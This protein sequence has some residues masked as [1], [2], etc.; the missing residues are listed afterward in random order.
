METQAKVVH[1][2]APVESQNSAVHPTIAV[3][4][5]TDAVHRPVAVKT[6]AKFVHSF[7][8]CNIIYFVQIKLCYSRTVSFNALTDDAES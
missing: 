3:E 5:Q 8:L 2:P 6:Q 7:F 4:T 1:P